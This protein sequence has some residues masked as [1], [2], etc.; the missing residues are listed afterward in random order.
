LGAIVEVSSNAPIAHIANLMPTARWWLGRFRRMR[1]GYLSIAIVI[2]IVVLASFTLPLGPSPGS[3]PP[4][5]RVPAGGMIAS[6]GTT[7]PVF[8]LPEMGPAV[9]C[10]A[11][12]QRPGGQ[13]GFV[14]FG[15]SPDLRGIIPVLT[16]ADVGLLWALADPAGRQEVEASA[17]SLATQTV[18][19]IHQVTESDTWRNDYRD[20]LRGVLDRATQYAWRAPDTQSAFRALLRASEPLMQDS[21]AHEIG[22]ALAPYI[23]DAFWQLVKT[24]TAQVLSLISGNPLDLSSIGSTLSVAL[25]DPKV[26]AA[27]GRVGPRMM[28]LPQSELLTE[29]FVANMADAL[30]RDPETTALLTRIAMDP[31]LGAQLGHVRNDVAAV[32]HQLGQVLWGLGGATS[33]NALAGLSMRSGIV[34]ESQP[35]ILLAGPDDAASL[36]H[37]LPGRATLLVPEK[38]P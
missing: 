6:D 4:L 32:V 20:A 15:N 12:Q 7:L 13:I 37:A 22:P 9:R 34:G 24:N 26:Q 14:S 2:A 19:S 23:S 17:A 21:I 33:M 8:C 35:L 27:L 1:G 28:D 38:V 31:R 5:W 30:Q 3:T 10:G 36:A 16:T 18:A 29:R 11:A 25:Q